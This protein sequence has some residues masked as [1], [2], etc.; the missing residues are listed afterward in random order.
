MKIIMMKKCCFFPSPQNPI[1][2]LFCWYLTILVNSSSITQWAITLDLYMYYGRL[3]R[4]HHHQT[5]QL[6]PQ[7]EFLK[8]KIMNIWGKYTQELTRGKIWLQWSQ[9][10]NNFR[11]NRPWKYVT[12][13]SFYLNFSWR[14]NIH[15]TE[16]VVC[17]LQYL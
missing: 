6:G 13:L 16:A 5:T 8:K 14:S 4:P 7:L 1:F 17:I 15:A 9:I 3:S 11:N 12:T 2:F 10:N